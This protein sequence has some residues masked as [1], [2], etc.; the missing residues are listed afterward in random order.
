M[1]SEA[2]PGVPIKCLIG[3]VSKCIDFSTD[4]SIWASLTSKIIKMKIQ[5]IQI[6]LEEQICSNNHL[7]RQETK[8]RHSS[9]LQV[10]PTFH[11]Q[12]LSC[13]WL[14]SLVSCL[15]L[16][17]NV[18]KAPHNY[19]AISGITFSDQS[20]FLMRC[21]FMG[22]KKWNRFSISSAILVNSSP[23]WNHS[24]LLMD[25]YHNASSVYLE[26]SR[27]AASVWPSMRRGE[28]NEIWVREQ[29][30]QKSIVPVWVL[31]IKNQ[32]PSN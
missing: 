27:L 26:S 30:L 21:L 13:S 7:L 32:E 14:L 1:H 8:A 24:P 29:L 22:R 9:K 12:F 18:S 5:F 19:G 16:P 20:P 6:Y 31:C 11:L 28:D 2:L 17:Q 4:T 10:W 25:C 23:S 3:S 15:V